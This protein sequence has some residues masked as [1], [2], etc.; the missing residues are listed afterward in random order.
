[1]GS[2]STV[3]NSTEAEKCGTIFEDNER[4]WYLLTGKKIENGKGTAASHDMWDQRLNIES[5]MNTTTYKI[6]TNT[7]RVSCCPVLL[8]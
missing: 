7:Y 1:M 2:L 5:V 6:E 8:V 4:K 3:N